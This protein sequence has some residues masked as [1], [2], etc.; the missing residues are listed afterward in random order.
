MKSNMKKRIIACMLC[1]VMLLSGAIS[2]L[3]Y[4]VSEESIEVAEIAEEEQSVLIG[5]TQEEQNDPAGITQ[6]EQLTSTEA[7]SEEQNEPVE[8]TKEEQPVST[9]AI[10]KERNVAE[11]ESSKE[12]TV[13][14]KPYTDSYEDQDVTIEVTAE[15]GIMPENAELNV[16]PIVKKDITDDMDAAEREKVEAINNQYDFTSEKLTEEGVRQEETVEGFL[17]YDISFLVDGA[18]VEPSGDVKVVMDFKKAAIPEGVGEDASVSVKHLKEV[19]GNGIVVEDMSDKASVQMTSGAGVQKVE[20]TT[21]SFSTFS[22]TWGTRKVEDTATLPEYDND[23]ILMNNVISTFGDAVVN[24]MN[25]GIDSNV[26]SGTT[27]VTVK[28]EWVNSDAYSE[29]LPESLEVTLYEDIDRNGKFDKNTDKEVVIDGITSTAT[30]RQ[31]EEWTHTWS[32]LPADTDFVVVEECPDG[33]KQ[34]DTIISNTLAV[35]GNIDR[36]ETC[37]DTTFAIGKNNILLVKQTGNN[38]YFLWT[39]TDLRLTGQEVVKIAARIGELGL[40]GAGNYQADQVIYKWGTD[41]LGKDITLA[42]HDE[43]WILTFSKT[44]VWSMFWHLSYTR[45]ENITLQNEIDKDASVQVDVSKVW[46]GDTGNERPDSITIQLYKTINGECETVENGKVM[47]E[48]DT[49]GNWNYSYKNLPKYGKDASGKYYEIQ[50]RIKEIK[51]GNEKVDG[52]GRAAG[53]QSDVTQNENGSFTITNTKGWEI[54]KISE[55]STDENKLTLEGA[56][57][58]L[59]E[60]NGTVFFSKSDQ[61]GILMWYKDQ[62]CTNA[63]EGIIPSGNYTLSEVSA[64]HGYAKSSEVWEIKIQGGVPVS[65]QTMKDGAGKDLTSKIVD[66]KSTYYFENVPIYDLPGAGGIGIYWYSIGGMLLMI[67]AALILYRNKCKEVLSS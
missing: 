63:F 14:I 28:K 31:K 16:T 34:L 49:V 32:N 54:I 22:I 24:I 65:V 46:S 9:E 8:A 56:V 15:A 35:A 44:K 26:G 17:A 38:P 67:A 42:L 10:Q 41:G 3:A 23:G 30:L 52:N 59:E 29:L 12:E 6:E 66:G 37:S 11:P 47:I 2:V 25:A 5:E 48:P 18:E 58:R 7:T 36:I 21:D 43:G 27:T 45:T 33:F 51:I 1:M 40:G 64:P 13:E 19:N 55:N 57:F 62:K 39:P 20:L 4:N 61:S 53:Y 50:Y 60:E